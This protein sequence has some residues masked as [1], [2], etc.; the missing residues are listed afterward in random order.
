[1]RVDELVEVLNIQK[2]YLFDRY[3]NF[4][5]TEEI[6]DEVISYSETLD[7]IFNKINEIETEE[8]PEEIKKD[9]DILND[10]CMVYCIFS[11]SYDISYMYRKLK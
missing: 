3:L 8:I 5:D 4:Y 9:Y 2:K 1:M 6:S 11:S 10:Y 7:T